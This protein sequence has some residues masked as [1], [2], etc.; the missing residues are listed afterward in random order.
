VRRRPYSIILL[1]DLDKAHPDIQNILLQLFD[2][3]RLTDG[4]G[5]LVD[6]TNTIIVATCCLD[7]EA[8]KNARPENREEYEQKL[9]SFLHK[10]FKT[11][12]LDRVDDI[13]PF[14]NLTENHIRQIINLQLKQVS[15]I[16]RKQKIDLSFSEATVNQLV[17]LCYNQDHGARTLKRKIKLEIEVPLTR[18]IL[19]GT[20][21]HGDS[22]LTDVDG[23]TKKNNFH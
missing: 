11:E 23:K 8:S 9:T 21:A 16:V 15:R 12:F 17:K 1:D 2:V 13:I 5:R 18:E 6:F 20:I 22:I 4:K 10:H 3:G 19:S 14:Y 7:S